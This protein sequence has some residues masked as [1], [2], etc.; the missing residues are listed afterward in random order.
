MYWME[1]FRALQN[2]FFKATSKLTIN[3]N[4]SFYLYLTVNDTQYQHICSNTLISNLN[5]VVD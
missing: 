1:E 4:V 3:R 2:Q 5:K